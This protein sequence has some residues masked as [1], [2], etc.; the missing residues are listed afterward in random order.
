MAPASRAGSAIRALGRRRRYPSGGLDRSCS[1]DRIGELPTERRH[2]LG[3]SVNGFPNSLRDLVTR[4]TKGNHTGQVRGDALVFDE[5]DDLG[6]R[7]PSRALE[8]AARP[9]G[10]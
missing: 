9:R 6:P 1:G 4:S 7:R 5:R 10:L 2:L 8:D 3:V